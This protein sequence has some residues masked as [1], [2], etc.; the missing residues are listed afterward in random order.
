MAVSGGQWSIRFLNGDKYVG[1]CT[2]TGLP[3]GEE[4]CFKSAKG[5]YTGGFREGVRHGQGT[6]VGPTGECLQG[7][8]ENGSF[9]QGAGSVV[10]EDGEVRTF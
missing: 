2:G 5:V 1:A 8:W 3:H 6:Y 10:M 4:G 9:V 7:I